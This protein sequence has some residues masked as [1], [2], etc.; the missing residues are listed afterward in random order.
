MTTV[1]PTPTAEDLAEFSEADIAA[2][3]EAIKL[4]VTRPRRAGCCQGSAR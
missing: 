2:L 3:E 4:F 1:M